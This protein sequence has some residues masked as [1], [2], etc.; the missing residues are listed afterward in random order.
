[1]SVSREEC[2]LFTGVN[3]LIVALQTLHSVL[4]VEDV[5][6]ANIEFLKQANV[7]RKWLDCSPELLDR[8]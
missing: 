3:R 6:D 1:M 4:A 7:I 8:R 2:I 5:E